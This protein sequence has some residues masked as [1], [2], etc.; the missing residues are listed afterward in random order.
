M[1]PTERRVTCCLSVENPSRQ[2]GV[3]DGVWAGPHEFPE[4]VDDCR[5][6]FDW[7]NDDVFG[8]AERDR[9]IL[10]S[11]LLIPESDANDVGLVE[12]MSMTGNLGVILKETQVL[13]P[14]LICVVVTFH[15]KVFA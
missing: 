12:A 5:S 4:A 7:A 10:L 13:N 1:D 6:L 3:Y 11:V 14:K 2:I 8:V 15:G 9:L